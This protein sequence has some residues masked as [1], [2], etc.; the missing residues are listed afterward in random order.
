MTKQED[1]NFQKNRAKRQQQALVLASRP[2]F[3]KDIVV[4][5]RKW[6]IPDGGFSG[7][8]GQEDIK[9]WWASLR[10]Q[11]DSWNK[12]KWP[13]YRLELIEFEKDAVAM[14]VPYKDYVERK[15]AIGLERP[16]NNFYNDIRKVRAKY[17]LGPSWKDGL[18]SYLFVNNSTSLRQHIGVSIIVPVKAGSDDEELHLVIDED[19]TLA[20]IKA[21]WPRVRLHQDSLSYKKRQKQQPVD[22][23]ILERG[24][25][26]Y[27]LRELK[28]MKLADVAEAINHKYGTDYMDYEV[29]TLIKNYKKTV[30]MN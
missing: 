4:L 22:P 27:E 25:K 8:E 24:A 16:I 28:N 2:D 1:I 30:S 12:E 20:D 7:N 29:Q 13:A 26:A 19:T 17:K 23:D 3:Q 5:R 10:K 18:R 6:K 9:K 21:A 15:E 14:K 11:E